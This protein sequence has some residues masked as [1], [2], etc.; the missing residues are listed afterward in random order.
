MDAEEKYA[1]LT[2]STYV[3]QAAKTDRGVDNQPLDFPLL[4][5][6]GETG[7]LLSAL[8]K[9]QRNHASSAAYSEEVAEELGDVLWYL[10]TIARRGGLHLSAVAGHLDVTPVSHPAI[11]RVLG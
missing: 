1:T 11:T 9:K 2:I 8:K 7:S 5:L 6:F 4:G 10:A 3:D